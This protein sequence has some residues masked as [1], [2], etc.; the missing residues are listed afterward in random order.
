MYFFNFLE[1]RRIQVQDFLFFLVD[2]N[3][4]IFSNKIITAMFIIFLR[5]NH[6]ILLEKNDFCLKNDL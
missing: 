4:S 2:F 5:K 3:Y 1:T 6:Q